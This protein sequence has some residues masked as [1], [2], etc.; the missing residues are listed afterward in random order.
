MVH[1]LEESPLAQ[2]LSETSGLPLCPWHIL[3]ESSYSLLYPKKN[4][5]QC[6][7]NELSVK[8]DIKLGGTWKPSNC[9]SRF[10]VAIVVPYR[11]RQTQLEIFL[12]YM[13]SF[14]QKQMINYR[15]LIIEQV[16]KKDFNRAK[17]LNIGYIEALKLFPYHCFIFHD[18]DLIPQKQNNIYACTHQ[19][20]HMSSSLN[21]FRYNLPY[22]GLFGGA[23]AIL[24]SQ[25]ELVNGFSNMF[26]GW[27]GEDDDFQSRINHK[28]LSICRFSPRVSRYVMLTHS[29]EL[30]SETRFSNLL[31][32]KNRYDVDGINTLVYTVRNST[33]KPLYTWILVDI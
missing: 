2:K 12:L 33:F 16:E 15:I 20:R 30:P 3:N 9:V 23:V 17:L 5:T 32:G 10:D 19:P 7:L 24:K 1:E 13:H 18:V 14:L 28:G 25:F 29:K 27:G 22:R 26:F 31:A 4:V 11:N 8:L 6:D 21:T